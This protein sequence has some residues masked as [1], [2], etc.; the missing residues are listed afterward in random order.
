MFL[1]CHVISQNHLIKGSYHFMGRIPLT[2]SQ[3][4]AKFFGHRHCYS[5]DIM[6]LLVEEEDSTCSRLNPA[7]LFIPKGHGLKAHDMSVIII[8]PI[9]V[10]RV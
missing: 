8:S 6:F 1:V 10:T 2:I 7:L 5:G 3:H 9:L 4:H